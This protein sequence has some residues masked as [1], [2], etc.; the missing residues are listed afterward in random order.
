MQ[1]L[2]NL[3]ETWENFLINLNHLEHWEK[4]IF[5]LLSHEILL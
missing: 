4:T 5:P 2:M 3:S 1:Y